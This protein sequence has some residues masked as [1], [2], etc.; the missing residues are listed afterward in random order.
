VN[1][2][3]LKNKRRTNDLTITYIKSNTQLLAGFSRNEENEEEQIKEVKS[4]WDSQSEAQTLLFI[5]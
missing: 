1:G 4:V 2:L 5:Q 3:I